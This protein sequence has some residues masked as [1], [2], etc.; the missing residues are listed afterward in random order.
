MN[1]VS[2]RVS[3]VSERVSALW[4]DQFIQFIYINLMP[5]SLGASEQVSVVERA[6]KA[7]SAEQANGWAARANEQADVRMA[8][9]SMR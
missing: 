9:Y 8:L 1:G 5:M 4:I 7:S 3:G 6:N 2:E